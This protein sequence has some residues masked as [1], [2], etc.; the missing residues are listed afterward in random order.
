MSSE[1]SPGP[2]P[3]IDEGAPSERRRA[4][5]RLADATR[6]VLHRLAATSAPIEALEAAAEEL[7]QLGAAIASQPHGWE[8]EG[9]AEAANAG[10]PRAMFDHSP[11]IGK[12]NPLAPP[13]VLW[14]EGDEMH[15]RGVFGPAYEGPPGCVHG[16]YVAAA[17]DEVLGAAQSLSASPGMTARLIVN[18]RSPTPL[19]TEL[20]FVGRIDR[21]EGRKVFTTGELHAGDTLC[22]EAEALF[23]S[24]DRSRFIELSERRAQLPPA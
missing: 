23:V 9:Y 1:F 21:V 4:M 19:Q 7:E 6:T 11:V 3:W 5:H 12:S 22:A 2:S 13:I 24:I 15:G 17:F 20:R 18:Y 14:V 10:D 8:Y 16:G